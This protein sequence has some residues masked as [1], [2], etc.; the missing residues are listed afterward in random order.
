M[1]T[2]VWRHARMLAK[3]VEMITTP[4]RRSGFRR[5]TAG[6]TW[7][8]SFLLA[9]TLAGLTGCAANEMGDASS[10][11]SGTL[12]GTG[13]SAQG[14]AQEVW[15]AAFQRS[16]AGVTINYEPAGSGA[17]RE[18]FLSGGV[19]FA[20]SDAALSD[21]ELDGEFARCA[22]GSAGLDLPIYVSPLVLIFNV[23]G[24][25]ELRLDAAVI[26][27]I[28]SGDITQWNDPALQ[29][30]N[31][32]ASL[33]DA[34]ITAV[35]RADDSGT[36]K[37][38]TDYLHQNEPDLW[39]YEADD[40]F[41]LREGEAAQGNSG[42]VS[43]VA[44][45]RNTIG[46]VDASRAGDLDVAQL[47]VGESFVPYSAEAAAAILDASPLVPRA[48]PHDLVVDV[49][50][51]S[52]AD[53]VYPLVLVSYLIVCETYR[54]AREAELVKSYASYVG[55]TEG[56]REAAEKAGSAPLSAEFSRKVLAA[57]DTVT[58]SNPD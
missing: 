12:N 20:A 54:D 1:L 34:P 4:P 13:S 53:G 16:N 23:D 22:D 19:S 18:Q 3:C 50:R 49:D 21:E 11:L 27:R 9:A 41:P 37:N 33:P 14:S 44:N 35:H 25:D 10:D 43:A 8:P 31:P 24:V 52:T 6:R 17:G 47:R 26:A 7:L 5:R 15:I 48:N 42:V 56:Q 45:G 57:V 29:E 32:A 2:W 51:T 30:L 38:F 40:R 55:S 58:V 46:Y 28:F 39:S 36:T